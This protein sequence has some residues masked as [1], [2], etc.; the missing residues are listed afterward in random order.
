MS[1]NTIMGDDQAQAAES[2]RKR[3]KV[4]DSNDADMKSEPLL[5]PQN[6]AGAGN[7]TS[8]KRRADEDEDDMELADEFE[9]NIR[10]ADDPEK[11]ASMDAFFFKQGQ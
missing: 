3:A 11:D 9:V 8:V 5:V 6:E 10:A 1:D 2:S 4:N 7:R